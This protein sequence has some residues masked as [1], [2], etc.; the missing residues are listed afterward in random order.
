VAL[1]RLVAENGQITL[2]REGLNTVAMA[3]APLAGGA[4]DLSEPTDEVRAF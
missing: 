4:Q 2:L 3:S 1:G